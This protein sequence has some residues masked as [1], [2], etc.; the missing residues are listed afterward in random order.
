[1]LDDKKIKEASLKA[2]KE[3]VYNNYMHTCPY[4]EGFYA[5]A[6]WMQ[7]EFLKDLW[8]PAAEIPEIGK[9]IIME[10]YYF[11]GRIKFLSRV[12]KATSH[13]PIDPNTHKWFY[14]DDLFSK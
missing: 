13:N 8:H 10:N 6:K 11:D 14:I 3:S 9:V 12:R 1:M 5:C 2:L 4:I 7:E